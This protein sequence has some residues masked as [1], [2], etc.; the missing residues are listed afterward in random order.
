MNPPLDYDPCTKIWTNLANNQLFFHWLLEW[1]KLIKLSTAMI[2]GNVE[3][4]RCLSNMGF[5][6]NKLRNKLATHLDLVVRM[7]AHKFFTLNI[8]PF[9]A[10][11][12]SC[13]GAKG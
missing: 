9:N 11:M 7:F 12:S 8:F 3:D 5:M 4:E 6:K 1:L 10:T 13:H 2:M